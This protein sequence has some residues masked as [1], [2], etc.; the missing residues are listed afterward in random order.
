[1][2]HSAALGRVGS[3]ERAKEMREREMG[4][5][6]YAALGGVGIRTRER[7]MCGPHEDTKTH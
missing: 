1:M 2:G 3:R 6:A 5:R 4:I 7:T